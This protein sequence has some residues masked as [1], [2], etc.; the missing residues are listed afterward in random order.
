MK[1]IWLAACLVAIASGCAT[2]KEWS[3]TGGSRSDGVVRLSY[4]QG[5]FESVTV[6]EAQGI[7]LATRRCATWGYTGAEAFG[8]VTR[9]CNQPGGFAGCA[10]WTVTKEY[11]CLGEGNA[12]STGSRV[13]TITVPTQSRQSTQ[14]MKWQPK[15]AFKKD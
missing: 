3:A 13:E 2:T 4:T 10:L 6:N 12:H 15:G 9:Q 8:G 5:E 11:Q 14:D 7:D 1:R